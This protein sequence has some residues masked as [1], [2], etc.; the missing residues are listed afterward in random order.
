MSR[1]LLPG[2]G[3]SVD[4]VNTRGKH[5]FRARDVNWDST[6]ARRINPD[7]QRVNRY[8]TTGDSWSNALAVSVSRRSSGRIPGFSV[9]YTL[10][11]AER[12]TE[13]FGF[14]AQDPNDPAA[15]KALGNNDRRHQV[16]TQLTWLLPFDIQIGGLVQAR[17]GRPVNITTGSD[18]NGD[19]N[20][21]D[22]PD[23]ADPNGDPFDAATY[24]RNFTGRV[25][26]LPRNYATGPGF[27][28]VD[29]RLSKIVRLR[30]TRFE[31][32]GEAFNLLNHRNANNPT[33]TLTSSTFGKVTSW[34]SPREI[35]F[36]VRFD[37]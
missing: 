18:N 3:L 9:A 25:G 20:R 22:R 12:D 6:T 21:N 19:S 7:W 27:V 33:A 17:T 8:E 28:Q 4:F 31:I 37:F 1:E 29:F 16:V 11:K 35:E 14:T 15:E 36:G 13:D 5:L 26:N 32:F 24:N 34:N 10:S 2:L 23:L 30:G